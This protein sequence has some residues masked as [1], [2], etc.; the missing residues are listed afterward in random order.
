MRWHWI[1]ENRVDD[2]VIG[3]KFWAGRGWLYLN[4]DGGFK[5]KTIGFSWYFGSHARHTGIELRTNFVFEREITF[6]IGLWHIFCFFLTIQHPMFPSWDYKHGDRQIGLR[7]FSGAL[8][9][10]IWRNDDEWRSND[11]RTRPIVIH[12]MDI[13]FG[14]T[15]HTQ[16]SLSITDTSISMPEGSYPVTVELYLSIWT[17][18]RWPF[19]KRIKRANVELEKPIPVPG[20]GENSW[21]IDDDAIMSM[22]CPA[23]T[24]EEAIAHVV[25]SALRTRRRHGGSLDWKPEGVTI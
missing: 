24:V 4:H 14:K 8:W 20:K 18:P 23:N 9:I 25:E 16:K 6:H 15:K 2:K 11:W 21:D 22:T 19:A 17:R 7:V 3:S 1:N 5:Q 10:D 13:L 12:P